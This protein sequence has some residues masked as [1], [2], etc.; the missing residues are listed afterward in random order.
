M[1]IAPNMGRKY[2]FAPSEIFRRAAV[3]QGIIQGSSV[4]QIF[5]PRLL[6]LQRRGLFPLERL[7][8][9]YPFENIN[10]AMRDMQ[11][12]SVVKPVLTFN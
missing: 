1:V 5:I 2:P 3:L 12:G 8:T 9:K 10:A 7:I 4:P 6:E 11:E